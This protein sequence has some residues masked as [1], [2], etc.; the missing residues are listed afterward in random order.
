LQPVLIRNSLLFPNIRY[1]G[2]SDKDCCPFL[3]QTALKP[4][5]A[6]AEWIYEKAY[7]RA[8]LL[9]L[10]LSIGNA[11]PNEYGWRASGPVCRDRIYPMWKLLNWR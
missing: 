1:I 10:G 4:Y 7:S 2:M 3:F 8:S 9:R 6:T 5:F 11:F